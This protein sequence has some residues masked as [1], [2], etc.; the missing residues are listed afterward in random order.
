MGEGRRWRSGPSRR[1]APDTRT[2]AQRVAT[3]A[4][5]RP[6]SGNSATCV[7]RNRWKVRLVQI[8]T[9]EVFFGTECDGRQASATTKRLLPPGMR[10]RLVIEPATDRDD[11]YGRLLRYVVRASDNL[12]VNT[13]LVAVGAAAPYFYA[14]RRG[15]F[16]N[17]LEALAMRASEE[18]RAVEGVSAYGV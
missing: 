13:R 15:T 1:P 6:A 10:V 14:G 17:G 18:A 7:L 2:H 3:S 9:P 11:D 16:A 8:D 4:S 12:N 5:C